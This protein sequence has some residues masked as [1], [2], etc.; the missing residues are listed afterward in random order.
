[1]MTV[2]NAWIGD[3]LLVWWHSFSRS[4][5]LANKEFDPELK[6][7]VVPYLQTRERQDVAEWSVVPG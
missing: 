3:V 6:F 1:M 2:P 4:D 5:Y 7:G